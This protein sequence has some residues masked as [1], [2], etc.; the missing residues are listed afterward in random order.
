MKV[1]ASPLA[2]ILPSVLSLVNCALAGAAE[3]ASKCGCPF[4]ISM[5]D[6]CM[7]CGQANYDDDEHDEF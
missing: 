1:Q 5:P 4:C 7:F 2:W 6:P 3:S